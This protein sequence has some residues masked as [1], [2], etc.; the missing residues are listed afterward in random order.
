MPAA[1]ANDPGK[2]SEQTEAAMLPGM[3]LDVPA[4]HA[5]HALL[6]EPPRFGLYVPAGHCSK[7][8]AALAAPTA[9]QKPPFA[10]WLQVDA[11][12][13]ALYVPIPHGVQVDAPVLGLCAPSAQSKQSTPPVIGEY[14]PS[15]QEVHEVPLV[16]WRLPVAHATQA[17]WPRSRSWP[18]GHV[19]HSPVDWRTLCSPHS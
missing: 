9:A 14:L 6:S 15:L 11:P 3:G 8:W 2:Q 4:G 1:A 10:H 17:S 13:E 18:G 16:A 19:P 12:G 5:T 7:V